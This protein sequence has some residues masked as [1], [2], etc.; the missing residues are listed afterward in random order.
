MLRIAVW[1][2]YVERS[3]NKVMHFDILVPLE[4]RDAKQVYDFGMS[5]LKSKPFHT[6][7]ISSKECT[8]CHI[9]KASDQVISDIN[10]KGYHIIE[11][12]NCN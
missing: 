5:Y 4:V 3:D 2:T 12:Q 9:E 8:F 1:D 7:A 10:E 11:M 6:G